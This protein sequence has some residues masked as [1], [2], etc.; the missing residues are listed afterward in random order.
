MAESVHKI[1]GNDDNNNNDNDNNNSSSNSSSSS[2]SSKNSDNENNDH[3]HNQKYPIQSG[4]PP[5][6][7]LSCVVLMAAITIPN[8]PTIESLDDYA[9]VE[10]F[11]HCKFPNYLSLWSMGILRL[12]I[13]G[14]VFS[15]TTYLV[16]IS[17]GW[18]LYANYLQHTKLQRVVIKITGVRALCAFTSFS[19]ILLGIGF[20]S[21]GLI[22][23][24]FYLVEQQ[25]QEGSNNDDDDDDV[26]KNIIIGIFQQYILHPHTWF[27]RLTFIAWELA[28]PFAMLTSVISK[29]VLWPQAIKGGKPHNLA[30]IRNQ[31]QHNWNSIFVLTETALL[32]GIPVCLHH[33]S[34]ATGFGVCY[35]LFT[36]ITGKYYF[37][38]PTVGPQYLYFFMDT[39]LGNVT[40]Y[41]MVGLLFAMTMLYLLFSVAIQILD[42]NGNNG[43]NNGDNADSLLIN[44]V[45]LLIGTRLVCKFRG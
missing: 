18:D 45:F 21:R 20:V 22:C 28:A 31:L 33:I 38:S 27:L 35:M 32:G 42:N 8:L 17:E 5:W 13:G 7:T 23:V 4:I 41:A 15:L 44:L 29:Y 3:E 25:Q 30:G 16:C 10:T 1:N 34:L 6:H 39:T 26:T 24:A 14:I 43:N 9:T 19:W 12:V 2:S 40:T 37:G 36:W 11:T